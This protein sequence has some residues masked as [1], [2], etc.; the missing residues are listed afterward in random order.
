VP[1]D[2]PG[3]EFLSADFAG[4]LVAV[5][6]PHMS[7]HLLVLHSL[8]ANLALVSALVDLHKVLNVVLFGSNS[9][10]HGALRLHGIFDRSE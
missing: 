1:L 7:V 5:R 8:I 3:V 2:R 6:S 9:T 10:C 4:W